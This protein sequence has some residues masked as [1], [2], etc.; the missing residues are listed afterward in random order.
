MVL[1]EGR[2][3]EP[4]VAAWEHVYCTLYTVHCTLYTVHCTWYSHCTLIKCILYT[5]YCLLYYLYHV[6]CTDH[7]TLYTVHY[8]LCTVKCRVFTVNCTLCTVHCTLYT[9]I[10]FF[11]LQLR[12]LF[13]FPDGYAKYGR[14]RKAPEPALSGMS[15]RIQTCPYAYRHVCTHTDRFS[16]ICFDINIIFGRSLSKFWYVCYLKLLMWKRAHFTL[17]DTY[18]HVCV[19]PDM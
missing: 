9:G 18:K 14:T 13:A 7:W 6:L 4:S 5:I 16:S 1:L 8:T 19:N 2:C 17:K 11:L 12:G 10:L 15:V 3:R